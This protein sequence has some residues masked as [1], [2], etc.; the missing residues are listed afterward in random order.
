MSET[1]HMLRVGGNRYLTMKAPKTRTMFMGFKNIKTAHKCK[2]FIENHKE[3]YG[4]WPSLN[5]DKDFE[6]IE[7]DT[8]STREPLY[9]DNKTIREVEDIMQRSGTGLMC[10]YEFGIIPNGKSFTLA[11]KAQEL[12]IDLDLEK[13]LESLEYIIDS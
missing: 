13:Y 2:E 3:K 5:L 4:N 12:Q 7:M 10:C 1:F 11:F 6:R 9:I 8:M